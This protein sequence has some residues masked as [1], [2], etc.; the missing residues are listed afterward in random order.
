MEAASDTPAPPPAPE[1][2]GIVPPPPP[3]LP[4]GFPNG[5]NFHELLTATMAPPPP[6]NPSALNDIPPPPMPRQPQP[7]SQDQHPDSEDG[8]RSGSENEESEDEDEHDNYWHEMPEDKTAPSE[9]E[10]AWINSKTEHSAL[11]HEHWEKRTFE[12]AEMEDIEFVPIASGRIDWSIEHYNGTRENPNTER[13]MRSPIVNIGG[14]DWQIKFFPKGDRSE[15]LSVYLECVTM[16]SPDFEEYGAFDKPP[17]PFLKGVE[18]INKRRGVAVQFSVVVYNPEEPRVNAMQQEQHQFCK[19]AHNHGWR[20]FTSMS[21]YDINLRHHGQRQAL[22]RNDKLAFKAFIRVVHDPTG[23][24]WVHDTR[25]ADQM[26]SLT[27]LRPF[28]KSLQYVAV[29]VPLLHFAPF[30]RFVQDL[31]TTSASQLSRWL[32]TL[33]LKMYTRKRST[34]YGVR[35]PIHDGDVMEML[36][37]MSL[38]FQN[39]YPETPGELNSLIGNFHSD[40]GSASGTSRLNTKDHTSIQ[41]AVDNHH[42]VIARPALLTLELQ[43]Q[44]HDKKE[45]KWKKLTHKVKVD[46]E[47]SVGG[48]HYTLFA[49]ITHKGHLQSSQ[50]NSYVRPRGAGNGW[51]AYRDSVVQ[52][53]TEKQARDIH[54]GTEEGDKKPKTPEDGYDSPFSEASPSDREVTCVVMYV[55]DDMTED[56]FNASDVETWVPPQVG[57]QEPPKTSIHEDFGSANGNVLVYGA[58]GQA[59]LSEEEYVRACRERIEAAAAAPT[60]EPLL[61]DGE[62]VVMRDADDDSAFSIDGQQTTPTMDD[63]LEVGT[64]DWLG[65]AYYEGHWQDNKYHGGGH[66]IA[67]NGDEYIGQFAKGQKSG[68]GKMIYSATGDVYEGEWKEDEQ[69]GKGKLVFSATG[70]VHEGTFKEGKATG[71]FILRGTVTDDDKTT[72]KVCYDKEMSTAFYDCGHVVACRECSAM[73]EVCPVCRKR[74]VARLQL[75][76]VRISQC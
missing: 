32:H 49:F 46:E 76:G 52:R 4:P 11:D 26:T 29:A 38:C 40:K 20:H 41:T 66:L 28:T 5:T 6:F 68:Y 62:D 74:I 7:D 15:Y 12:T 33:L 63:S 37:R 14:Y 22:L 54:S 73:L 45:R 70:N 65:R 1:A 21:R 36:W 19:K 23:C 67:L 43:R 53:L 61:M 10:L 34:N 51:Y 72:C 25:T 64:T 42:K 71:E 60:P 57:Q 50:Y 55:R 27:G 39:E 75:Y 56:T 24:Q 31:Q 13:I 44:E 48:T 9:D 30:R 3:V 69:D 59:T 58:T 17:F 8:S 35:G 2:D 16:A 18:K 47:I